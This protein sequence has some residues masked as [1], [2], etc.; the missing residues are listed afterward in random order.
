MPRGRAAQRGERCLEI[1]K[2]QVKIVTT[3]LPLSRLFDVR[4]FASPVKILLLTTNENE[5]GEYI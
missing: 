5:M 3:D 1:K 2:T 4:F